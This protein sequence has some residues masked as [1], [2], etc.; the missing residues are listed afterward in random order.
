MAMG[1][2]IESF[3]VYLGFE[4]STHEL[5]EWFGKVKEAEAVAAGL[6]AA[7]IATTG[8]MFAFV[9]E[10]AEGVAELKEF[11]DT[12]SLNIE[13]LQKWM[14]AASVTGSTADAVK[15]S[16][17]QLNQ[18]M[19]AL[20]AGLPSRGAR[21]FQLLGLQ[22]KD[23]SGK[24]KNVSDMMEEVLLKAASKGQA[25]AGIL[26]RLGIDPSLILLAQKGKLG[27]EQL[28]EEAEKYGVVSEEDAERSVQLKV[29]WEKLKTS[30]ENL[31][32]IIAVKLVPG[33]LAIVNGLQAW[34]ASHHDMIANRIIPFFETMGKVFA[35]LWNWF[36]LILRVVDSVAH[37]FGG[38][39]IVS[40]VLLTVLAA[41]VSYGII[42]F[43]VDLAT[44]TIKVATAFIKLDAAAEAL[45]LL[46]GL[47]GLAVFLLT[48][49]I[50]NFIEGN[51]S[52]IGQ[53]QGKYPHAFGI[54]IG[55]LA[56]F[57]VGLALAVKAILTKMLTALGEFQVQLL[58]TTKNL[59]GAAVATWDW[60]VALFAA[61]W[62]LLL[63]I[64]VL[65][66]VT[67]AIFELMK[68]WQGIQDA[69]VKGW[70][71]VG[72]EL[73]SILDKLKKIFTFKE[74][75]AG[76]QMAAGNY[77]SL[78]GDPSFAS[79]NGLA[80]TNGATTNHNWMQ[81]RETRVQI[82]APISITSTDP[83][84]AGQQVHDKLDSMH[85]TATRN[86]QSPIHH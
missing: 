33:V 40:A 27:I 19:G 5:D 14:Y 8:A 52:L 47:L 15:E 17:A 6:G 25:G 26:R 61:E 41:I 66:L 81:N 16:M 69:M 60:V 1:N 54:A 64:A 20:A 44:K 34:I 55:M 74:F 21:A 38:W 76:F 32:K 50:M 85:R 9:T 62:P 59:W 79:A 10:V 18:T 31:G 67:F 49:D 12:N 72:E 65:A 51:N 2:L 4:V 37:A 82:N 84:E 53:L 77:S 70:H 80:M 58:A 86:A 46:I 56:L 23:A 57:S 73:D 13:E 78:Y 29:S 36:L 24:L 63:I 28:R 7:L 11:A 48:D 68:H 43:M 83:V 39:K 45:P 35:D 30:G 71:K 75:K 22:A 3:F 42:E